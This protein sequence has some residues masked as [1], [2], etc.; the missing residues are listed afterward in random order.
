MFHATS[1]ARPP[2]RLAPRRRGLLLALVCLACAAPAFAEQKLND[3]GQITCY[4][5]SAAT[6]TVSPATFD[7]ETAGFDGQ[8]CT[9]GA[10]AADSLGVQAKIGSSVVR[11]RDYTKIANDGSELDASVALG[12]NPGDWGCTRDNVTGLIWEIKATTGLRAG[13]TYTWYRPDSAVNGGNPG[14]IGSGNTCGFTLPSN[15][16]NIAA[17]VDAVNALSGAARLCGATDWRLPTAKELQSLVNYQ[18]TS[19]PYIDAKWFPRTLAYYYWSGVNFAQ[20][21]TRALVAG[22]NNGYLRIYSKSDAYYVM[23]VRGGQ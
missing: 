9:R 12:I 20:D 8:D 18:A 3:T 23:L 21:A 14:N 5:A 2:V 4:D 16:C 7:P 15:Q 11:G 10:S 13:Y 17:Y 19:P 1:A 22:F 6:G